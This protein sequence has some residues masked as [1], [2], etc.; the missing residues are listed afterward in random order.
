MTIKNIMYMF[1]LI[2]FMMAP[3][4]HVMEQPDKQQE[5]ELVQREKREI[6]PVVALFLQ[7]WYKKKSHLSV[8]DQELLEKIL[9][10]VKQIRNGEA[11]LNEVADNDQDR[12]ERLLKEHNID[13]NIKDENGN[14]ALN[15]AII[16]NK[17]YLLNLVKMLLEAGI[18]LN[19]QNKD[20]YTSLISAVAVNYSKKIV[21]ILLDNGANPNMQDYC[22]WTALHWA[23]IENKLKMARMLLDK[24]VNLNIPNNIGRTALHLAVKMHN[25]KIVQMLIDYDANPT[26]QDI[27]GCTALD[28]A[29][30]QEDQ[31]I[32]N[33]LIDAQE[34]S[35]NIGTSKS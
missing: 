32:I 28:W 1:L 35:D 24:G 17:P 8:L 5:T 15:L 12:V 33:L 3:A 20:G 26:I 7:G 2:N 23:A 19:L 9:K 13:V 31:E 11:L 6:D 4:I 18:N 27:E 14:T 16:L 22:G 10:Y 34:K 29:I 30:K 21:Q 25:P